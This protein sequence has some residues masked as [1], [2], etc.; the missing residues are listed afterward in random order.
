LIADNLAREAEVRLLRLE[1]ER[2][3]TQIQT[4][5]TTTTTTDEFKT[6]LEFRKQD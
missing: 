3:L 1:A 6:G 4:T 2:K 5:T